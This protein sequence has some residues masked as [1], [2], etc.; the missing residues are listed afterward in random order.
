[1]SGDIWF[2]ITG[3]LVLTY[4]LYVFVSFVQIFYRMSN[5]IVNFVFPKLENEVSGIKNVIEGVT[6]FFISI[7]TLGGSI[8]SLVNLIK[9]LVK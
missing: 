7:T 1:M 3:I 5:K 4:L 2:S 8:L 9:Q 6:A